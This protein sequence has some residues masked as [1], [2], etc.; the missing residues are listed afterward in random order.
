MLLLLATVRGAL[1]GAWEFGAPHSLAVA[2]AWIAV[3]L[4]GAAAYGGLAFLLEDVKKVSVLPVF[5]RGSS[6]VSLEGDLTAQLEG[7]A[8][9]AGVRQTL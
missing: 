1:A 3:A 2:A 8:D 7:I 5:R 9:E 6:R 4:F